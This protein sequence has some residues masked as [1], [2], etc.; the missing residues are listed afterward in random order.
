MFKKKME[1]ED[2]VVINW[3]DSRTGI[4]MARHN[5]LELHRH[6]AIIIKSDCTQCICV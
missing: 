5:K 6:T 4:G 1:G 2:T 3:Q